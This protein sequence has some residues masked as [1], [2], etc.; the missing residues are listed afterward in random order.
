MKIILKIK[1]MF[2]IQK[3]KN[4][5]NQRQKPI[6]TKIVL[7]MIKKQ[8]NNYNSLKKIMTYKKEAMKKK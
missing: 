4:N 7:V 2:N 1:M 5:L 3:V 8:L 6:Q